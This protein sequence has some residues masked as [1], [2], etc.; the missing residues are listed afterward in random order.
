MKTSF[1]LGMAVA[2]LC[3]CADWPMTHGIPNLAQVEPGVWRGGQPTAAGWAWLRAQGV[4]NDV[5]LDTDDEGSDSNAVA[6]GMTVYPCPVSFPR[7]MGL[8]PMPRDLFFDNALAALPASN[9]FVHCEHGQDR[10]G[11]FVAMWRMELNRDGWLPAAAE[12]EMLAHG[13]HKELVGLWERWHK[14]ED[15]QK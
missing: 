5:K 8:E 2:L 13:F 14:F 11:L 15:E 9:I 12:R 4:T 3:G 10:T 7:Q 1:I 6:L